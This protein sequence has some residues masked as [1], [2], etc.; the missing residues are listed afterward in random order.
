MPTKKRLLQVW[1]LLSF[2]P[3]HLQ[4]VV[5]SQKISCSVRCDHST[6]RSQHRSPCSWQMHANSDTHTHTQT[7]TNTKRIIWAKGKALFAQRQHLD[8]FAHIVHPPHRHVHGEFASDLGSGDDVSFLA[9]P[10]DRNTPLLYFPFLN[11]F[12]E[13]RKM[14]WDERFNIYVCIYIYKYIQSQSCIIKVYS[15]VS[16][17][18]TQ[19]FHL[20][21]QNRG[22]KVGNS[23]AMVVP[24]RARLESCLKW[25]AV[26]TCD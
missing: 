6:K 19:P 22:A 24:T 21:S 10:F 20:N 8:E 13:H 15:T 17:I 9:S 4:T 11:N 1:P 26:K 18:P 5:N 12:E 2:F 7:E 14:K 3:F 16:Y 23:R 25:V